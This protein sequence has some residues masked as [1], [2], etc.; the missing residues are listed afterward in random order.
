MT[1]PGKKEKRKAQAAEAEKAGAGA[2]ASEQEETVEDAR[3][4][5]EPAPT[6]SFGKNAQGKPYPSKEAALQAREDKRKKEGQKKR[7]KPSSNGVS[8]FEEAA[9]SHASTSEHPD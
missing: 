8:A 5:Q 3:P 1:T 7:R 9:R 6:N 4:S 2:A